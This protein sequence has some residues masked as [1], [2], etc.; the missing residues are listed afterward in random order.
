MKIF[1]IFLFVYTSFSKLSFSPSKCQVESNRQ[2]SRV[3]IAVD[4][5]DGTEKCTFTE[6][7]KNWKQVKDFL[8][9]PRKDLLKKTKYP[10]RVIIESQKEELKGTVL[11]VSGKKKI[12][13]A[14]TTF[15]YN[16]VFKEEFFEERG[17]SGKPKFRRIE[18][19]NK[20]IQNLRSRRKSFFRKMN[21]LLKLKFKKRTVEESN[22]LVETAGSG[23]DKIIE[24]IVPTPQRITPISQKNIQQTVV[25]KEIKKLQELV[26]V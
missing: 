11:F 13:V 1:F 4:G 23:L 16:H 24:E 17:F 22:K 7:P 10:C 25:N 12:R 6:I 9:I 21:K 20:K 15:S 14:E 26:H 5:G 3:K 8:Y 19:L 18:N 2:W